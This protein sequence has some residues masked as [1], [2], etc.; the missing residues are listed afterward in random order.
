MS[1]DG[2]IMAAN[3]TRPYARVKSLERMPPF[4]KLGQ[5]GVSIQ[6]LNDD[7]T[8]NGLPLLFSDAGSE[9]LEHLIQ[10]ARQGALPDA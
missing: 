6:R 1:D 9:E 2:V 10:A 5:H 8:P 3:G 7:G 4:S